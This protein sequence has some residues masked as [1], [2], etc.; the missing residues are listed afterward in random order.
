MFSDLKELIG[1]QG[2]GQ[3][4]PERSEKMDLKIGAVITP[5]PLE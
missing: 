5:P 2:G 4:L 3:R 1:S